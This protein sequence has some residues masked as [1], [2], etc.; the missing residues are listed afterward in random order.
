MEFI[1]NLPG[2][3]PIHT[4]PM[5]ITIGQYR[6]K[7]ALLD[8][9]THEWSTTEGRVRQIQQPPYAVYDTETLVSEFEQ[10]F[11]V[12]QPAVEQWIFESV[13]H[14]EIAFLTYQEVMRLRSLQPRDSHNLLD[15][16]MK[17]QCL[18]IISQGYG[19]VW[20]N[21]IPG[22]LEYDYSKMGRSSYAAY[23]RNSRDRP[24]PA[25]INQQMD[26][27]ALKLLKKL[28]GL[29]HKEI[30]KR[31]FMP[32]IKPWYELYLALYVI[33]WNMEYIHR[34]AETYILSKNGTV[35]D[36]TSTLKARANVHRPLNRMSI[37][38]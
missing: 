3:G 29:C 30:S 9:V 4:R 24:L 14:D 21:D 34:S 27:A 28:E 12:L 36:W 16:C 23:D 32:K 31:V 17:V 1:W 19:T 13:Q 18:S 7:R 35:S 38:W 6:P 22:I 26:V 11:L 10:Y 20:S 2:T 15:L 37:V 8:A 5:R 33:F 25:A